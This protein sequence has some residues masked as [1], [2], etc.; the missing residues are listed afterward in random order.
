VLRLEV[1]QSEL[2]RLG[3]GP[4]DVR[5]AA[6]PLA[7]P[8]LL[9]SSLG[10]LRASDPLLRVTL[11]SLDASSAVGAVAT[12][13]VD[14]ALVDGIAGPNEP[15]HLVDAGLLASAAIAETPLVVALS[16]DHPLGCHA[17][18]SLDS[19]ADAPWVSAP[20]LVDQRVVERRRHAPWR[21][22]LRY[23]GGD[24]ATLLELVGAGLGAAL[25]PAWCCGGHPAV[26][27]IPLGEP[28]LVHRTELV[29]LRT[30]EAASNPVARELRARATR[31]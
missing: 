2:G 18:L 3:H 5:V 28:R 12:G 11:R 26:V 30:A 6:C 23:D 17:R 1:A 13:S 21:E 7:A 19:L 16:V 24:L 14:V 15:L 20:A 25:L 9:A 10:A 22:S 8:R 27:G 29:T 4:S 31:S